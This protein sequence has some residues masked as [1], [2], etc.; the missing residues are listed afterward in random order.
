ML[1][2]AFE[3]HVLII[4]HYTNVYDRAMATY[5]WTNIKNITDP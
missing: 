2:N 3:L 5:S 1:K 4:I